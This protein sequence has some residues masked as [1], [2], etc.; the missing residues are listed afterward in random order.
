MN[1]YIGIDVSK[2]KIDVAWL[3]DLTTL[4][5]TTK[6]IKNSKEG[7]SEL[8][9][10]ITE[11]IT[12]PVETCHCIM[13][14]TGIYHE[15]LALWLSSMGVKVSVCNPAQVKSFSKSLGTQH[16]TD[17]ID[18][19]L[20]ARFGA[21]FKPAF[22]KP[23]S[24]AMRELNALIN[25]LDAV[26]TDLRREKNRLEKDEFSPCSKRV[27]KSIKTMIKHLE[28]EQKSL[29]KEIDEHIKKDPDLK[30]NQDLLLSIPAVGRVVSRLMLSVIG[31]RDFNVAGECA[32]FLGVIPKIQE[33]GVFKG[34]SALSK[35]GNPK[36][37]AKLYMSAMVGLQ[38]NP[39]IMAQKERLVK[40]GKNPMQIIGAAM[41]KL[42]HICFGVLKTQTPYEFKGA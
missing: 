5:F 10:W 30:R 9:K 19:I 20:L 22:W 33:S 36:A 3:Q 6:I 28:K 40:S 29:D 7:F 32:A 23:A 34:R 24:K 11:E 35:K 8:R 25:R 21:L 17:K 42:V 14:A 1:T 16:K 12:Q 26:E 41:R 27:A 2:E 37:R 39:D 15:P 38:H 4:K 18:S 13:E 31:S